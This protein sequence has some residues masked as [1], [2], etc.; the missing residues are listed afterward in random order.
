M[1][2]VLGDDLVDMVVEGPGFFQ[3]VI[4]S[5]GNLGCRRSQLRGQDGGLAGVGRE[6]SFDVLPA[7]PRGD[8]GA[9]HVTGV[10]RHGSLGLDSSGI[11]RFKGD[12]PC[13]V[14]KGLVA[15]HDPG[16]P[17]GVVGLVQGHADDVTVNTRGQDVDQP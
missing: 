1:P 13:A 7:C 11:A 15:F 2:I 3:G 6:V 12:H 10:M 8:P 16:D 17:V 4:Q 5:P 9:W 14:I